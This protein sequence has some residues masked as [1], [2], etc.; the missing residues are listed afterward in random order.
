MK[1]ATPICR[2]CGCTED[3]A[4]TV[5]PSLTERAICGCWW[6]EGDL[7]SG[8]T[9]EHERLR[10]PVVDRRVAPTAGGALTRDRVP[11]FGG[12]R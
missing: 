4:C 1:E 7:C 9:G 8:C 11:V 10:G 6:V 5:A 12:E 2:G 3:D